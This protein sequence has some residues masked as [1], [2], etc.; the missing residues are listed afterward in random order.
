MKKLLV[1][2][3]VTTIA[4]SSTILSFAG[5]WKS[6]D[7]GWK[8]Q[9][10]DGSYIKSSWKEINEKWYFFNDAEYML[11]S[12]TTPDG[13]TVNESGEWVQ[14]FEDK[15]TFDLSGKWVNENKIP[16][17]EYVYYPGEQTTNTI[18]EGS[19]S[20][21]SN[22]NYIRLYKD[23]I[24]NSGIYVP[25]SKAGQLDITK[26][27]VFLVGRD[28][29]AGSYKLSQLKY[30]RSSVNMPHCLIFNTIPSSKD[31]F[32]AKKNLVKDSFVG[33]LKNNTITVKDG[34]YVQLILCTAD[35]VRP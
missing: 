2:L 26:E 18:I 8:Y 35:F 14:S 16:E 3:M 13:Y 21:I 11:S 28:I 31:Q 24:V 5:E 23:D 27:G 9:N 33:K 30:D 7:K 20:R 1:L 32:A 25:V 12:T 17:G 6:D 29:K 22:F 10:D 15:Y 4:M 34:Q 19:S